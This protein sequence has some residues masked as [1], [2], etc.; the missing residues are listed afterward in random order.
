MTSKAI[1]VGPKGQII[2][3]KELRDEIGLVGGMLVEERVAGKSIV[4][5]PI[6]VE[7]LIKR[8]ERTAKSVSLVWP[9]GLTS[10]EAVRRNRE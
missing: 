7:A 5:T 3:K 4:I 8:I 10:V 1:R 6:D 2:I 9:K